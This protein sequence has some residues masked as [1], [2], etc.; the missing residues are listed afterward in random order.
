M[1]ITRCLCCEAFLF[2]RELRRGYCTDCDECR[3]DEPVLEISDD[4]TEDDAVRSQG[5]AA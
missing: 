3:E 5:G 2:G 4:N 1:K